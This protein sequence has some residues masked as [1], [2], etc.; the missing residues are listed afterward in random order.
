MFRIIGG[1]TSEPGYYAHKEVA[2]V[3]T[4]DIPS[5]Y[6]DEHARQLRFSNCATTDD[7]AIHLVGY[8]EKNND[9]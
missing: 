6:I 5:E 1:D 3:P 4:F 8:M 7:H 2:M 9:Y